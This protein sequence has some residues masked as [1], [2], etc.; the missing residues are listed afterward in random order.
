MVPRFE[1]QTGGIILKMEDPTCL[2]S[3]IDTE[4]ELSFQEELW[5][6]LS[7]SAIRG[8]RLP[9]ALPQRAEFA[10]ILDSGPDLRT[11]NAGLVAISARNL[12]RKLIELG[13]SRG[14]AFATPPV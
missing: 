13:S 3:G 2:L 7:G 10:C 6:D 12:M 11:I 14:C 1:I 8:Q 9:A 5:L 4:E